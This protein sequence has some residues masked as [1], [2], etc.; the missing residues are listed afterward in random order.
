MQWIIIAD[1]V[2]GCWGRGNMVL[3][4]QGNH[5]RQARQGITIDLRNFRKKSEFKEYSYQSLFSKL[6]D[7]SHN[8]N[9]SKKR[10]TG[11]GK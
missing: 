6:N 5:H 1:K 10:K 7:N 4:R 3:P 9:I 2:H 11:I 8:K